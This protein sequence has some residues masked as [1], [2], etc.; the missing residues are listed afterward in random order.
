M[1]LTEQ[2]LKQAIRTFMITAEIPL[3]YGW[4]MSMQ[5]MFI[6]SNVFPAFV[7]ALGEIEEVKPCFGFDINKAAKEYVEGHDT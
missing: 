3:P 1:L 2:S 4:D 7:K 5:K 6:Q